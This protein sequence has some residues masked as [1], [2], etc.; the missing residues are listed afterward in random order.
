MAKQ[1][2]KAS[3]V[4]YARLDCGWRRGSLI[5][6]RNNRIK[7]NAMLYNGVEYSTPN[8]TYQIRTYVG[9]QAKYTTVGNDLAAAQATLGR[10]TATRQIESA[11][12]ALGI[13]PEQKPEEKKSLTT[14][15]GEYLAEKKSPAL[16]LSRTMIGTYE[17]TLTEFLNLSK[18]VY[19]DEVTGKD[20]T[21]YVDRLKLD[22]Y[23]Q[24]VRSM[25]YT[26]LRGFLR[27]VG[28]DVDRLI[29]KSTSRRLMQKP[30]TKTDPF[31]KHEIDTL[32]AHC[33]PYYRMVFSL[34]LMTGLR[35]EEGAHL[36]WAN[37]HFDRNE[38]AIPA[39]QSINKGGK[40]LKFNTKSK[41]SRIVPLFG[42]LKAELLKWREQHPDAVY[43]LGAPGKDTPNT[44]WLMTGKRLWHEAGLDCHVCAGCA[45]GTGCSAF[46]LHRLRHTFAHTCVDNGVPIQKLS[47]W[48]GH[49][50]ITV[51]VIYLSGG[52]QGVVV[53]PFGK[54][55]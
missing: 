22:G 19:A 28:V 15:V 33:D 23:G 52:S 5:E 21:D 20:I 14:L 27:R 39:S 51:T 31:S 38:I 48:L 32:L 17:V 10:Y 8:P 44:G 25:R 26:A 53:D 43:V 37:V 18:R 34:L 3:I 24:K 2:H 11:N 7:E 12:E 6:T 9:S 13:I 29:D 41:K 4:V 50:S 49:H 30:E 46:Y 47:R 16:G 36:T 42:S 54:A 40:V 45:K 35:R 55:A 1:N